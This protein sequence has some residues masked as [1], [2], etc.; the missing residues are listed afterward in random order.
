VLSG[1]S[2]HPLTEI[3]P[4]VLPESTWPT[5]LPEGTVTRPQ[6]SSVLAPGPS[7]TAYTQTVWS[8]GEA[9]AGTE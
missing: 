2:A 3:P 4:I 7:L 1:S 6:P 8:P 5:G 9:V